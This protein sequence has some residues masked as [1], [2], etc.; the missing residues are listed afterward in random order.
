MCTPGETGGITTAG[1]TRVINLDNLLDIA[2]FI[3]GEEEVRRS[4]VGFIGYGNTRP[5][6]RVLLAVDTHSDS[7]MVENIARALREKEAKVDIIVVDV[8]ADREFDE[9]DEIR[10]IIR[11]KPWREEPRRYE[12]IPWIEDL[13]E[14]NKYDLL[15]HGKGGGPPPTPYR[16]EC[17]PWVTREHF[18]SKAT[19]FPRELHVRINQKA[20]ATIWE[21]GKGGKIH[22]T[23]PE[24]TDLTWTLWEEYFDGSRRAFSPVPMWGHLMA[25]PVTP[26][27]AKEDATGVV[28]GTT[29]HFSRPFP[30]LKV[31]LDGSHIRKIEGGGKYG[32]AWNELL[33]ETRNIKYPGFPGPGLFWLWEMAIGTN[34][35]I[36][37]PAN[38][39]MLSSAGA[40]WERRRSGVIHVGIGTGWR[41]PG[42][43]WAAEQ[44]IAYG[45]LHVHLLFPTLEVIAKS[46]EKIKVIDK[47]RLTALDDPE[48]R[49]LASRYGDP[50]ELLRE[51]WIPRIP[52]INAPGKYE[53]FAKDPAPYIYGKP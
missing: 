18:A 29:G 14:T 44:R 38:I 48:I 7:Q 24:G 47:G 27:I 42:E 41:S 15:I 25:H 52:G 26:L 30:Y 34:V 46:G 11:R 17:I 19:I 9:L 16:Y 2:R 43:V 6:Q 35:K 3:S 20:W 28:A 21:N 33:E 8:G 32:E 50:D 51:D 23:D 37:R 39:N 36:C 4:A 10:A 49:N 13:M 40:E 12:G 31:H 53:E 1:K 5:G 22:L 45:H